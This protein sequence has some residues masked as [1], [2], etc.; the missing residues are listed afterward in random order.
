MLKNLM[1]KQLDNDLKELCVNITNRHVGSLGNQRASQYVANRFASFGF[2][3]TKPEFTCIDWEHGSCVLKVNGERVN[4]FISPYSL[5]CKVES[6]FEAASSIN[7]LINKDFN[8]KIAVL[9][10][11]ICKEQI[12]PKNFTFY[13]PEEHKKIVQLLEEKKPL[14]IVAVT[15]RNP[16]LTG[17]LYPFPLF[18]DG[19]FNIPSVYLTEEEGEKILNNPKENIYLSIESQRIKSRGCNVIGIKNSAANKRIVFCAHID[20]KKGTPGVLD[21]GTGIAVLLSLASFLKD[22]SGE[23][24]IELV[25][26]NG[27]D[28]YSQPGQMLYL[29][30]NAHTLNQ[31]VLNINIDGAGYKGYRNSFCCFNC[32]GELS[33]VIEK[34]FKED[35]KFVQI[36]PWYQGDHMIFVMNGIPS[37]AI[38]SENI[39]QVV[40][41]I[42]HTERDTLENVDLEKLYNIAYSFKKLI[43]AINGNYS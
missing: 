2:T 8:G 6:S 43:E 14:A 32:K 15:K 34:I 24:G 13:N 21:N 12:M 40:S 33:G 39:Y 42:A 4:A 35:S 36:D 17:A 3:V 11:E 30:Q 18:E 1:L 9:H 5:P 27:E 16:E 23:Y 38:S 10:G 25:A 41:E 26:L 22:Y 37:I 31:I 7:E 19:D 28:Y 20:T 29:E